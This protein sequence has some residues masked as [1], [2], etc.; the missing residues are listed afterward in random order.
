MARATELHREDDRP[1][2]RD[3]LADALGHQQVLQ[4][5]PQETRSTDANGIATGRQRRE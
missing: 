5:L 1:G 2:L 3:A 4:T